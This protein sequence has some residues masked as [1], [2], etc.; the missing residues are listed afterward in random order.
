MN[1]SQTETNF[2]DIIVVFCDL[3]YITWCVVYMLVSL[4]RAS[5]RWAQPHS[6]PSSVLLASACYHLH[7]SSPITQYGTQRHR[8][9]SFFD[10]S[11][12]NLYTWRTTVGNP[13]PLNFS[14]FDQQ[15]LDSPTVLTCLEGIRCRSAVSQDECISC[16]HVWRMKCCCSSQCKRDIFAG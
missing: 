5:G 2:F 16:W 15:L 6:E 7:L 9:C 4:V 11:L 13:L 1:N 3:F 14:G 10:L 8:M 12:T